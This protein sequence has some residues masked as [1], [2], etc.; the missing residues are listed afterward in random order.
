MYIVC[1]IY[2]LYSVIHIMYGI[3]DI[4]NHYIIFLHLAY[5]QEKCF[6]K[7]IDIHHIYFFVHIQGVNTWQDYLDVAYIWISYVIEYFF[8]TSS[9][10]IFENTVHYRFINLNLLLLSPELRIRSKIDRIRI[11]NIDIIIEVFYMN[12]RIRSG[13]PDPGVR[14]N[15]IRIQK[16]YGSGSAILV[17]VLNRIT[18][19]RRPNTFMNIF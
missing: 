15:W 7:S 17:S 2:I 12:L 6:K 8:S 5:T 18:V 10:F 9:F 3:Q 19:S 4:W 14:L 13:N 16:K 1:I 11:R